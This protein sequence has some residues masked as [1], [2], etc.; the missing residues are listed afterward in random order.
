MLVRSSALIPSRPRRT[1][2]LTAVVGVPV[3][4]VPTIFAHA[5]NGRLVVRALD[6]GVYPWL[7]IA[8]AMMWGFAVVTGE[9]ARSIVRAT[10]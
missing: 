10:A 4:L 8:I 7:P 6:S 2:F 1:A 3:I 5:A 9:W